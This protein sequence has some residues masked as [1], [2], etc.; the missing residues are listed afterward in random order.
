M[1]TIL[2]LLAIVFLIACEKQEEH[3]WSCEQ[4][5]IVYPN[6]CEDN[7]TLITQYDKCG[8]TYDDIEIYEKIYTYN[9]IK[10]LDHKMF[11]TFVSSMHCMKYT[12][13]E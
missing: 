4:T 1:K 8:M 11:L 5:V 13:F 3:C 6:W 9:T 10:Q 12:C 2:L 7:D